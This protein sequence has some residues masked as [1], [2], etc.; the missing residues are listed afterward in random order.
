MALG[1]GASDSSAEANCR[2]WSTGAGTHRVQFAVGT[3]HCIQGIASFTKRSL[4]ART[5]K[6]FGLRAQARH[7]TECDSRKRQG[8]SARKTC[9]GKRLSSSDE[10]GDVRHISVHFEA[11]RNT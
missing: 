3:N 5:F 6:P 10:P 9:V 4:D 1:Q 8:F 7:P 2:F 11:S